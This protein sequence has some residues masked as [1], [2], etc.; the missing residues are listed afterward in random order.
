MRLLYDL[1]YA[2][3]IGRSR[4][5]GGGE[6]AK[7]ILA[8]IL[9]R[10]PERGKVAVCFD[11]SRF[12]D[13]WLLGLLG[14][15][16]VTSYDVKSKEDVSALL[17]S[18]S[19]FDRFYC[20]LP[21]P[22]AS[23]D[24]SSCIE[25]YGTVHGL[26]SLE[27]PTDCYEGYLQ[28]LPGKVKATANR[29]FRKTF[30]NRH[31]SKLKDCVDRLDHVFTVSEHSRYAIA[32]AFGTSKTID[33]A[34]SP[35]KSKPQ[36]IKSVDS[37]KGSAFILL[38]SCNRWEKNARRAVMAL[39]KL[40][41]RGHLDGVKVACCGVSDSRLFAD[42]SHS[43]DFIPLGYVEPGELEWLYKDCAV[44][45]YPT[46]NEGFGYPPLEAMAYGTTC[47]VSGVCSL[48]E[49]CGDAVYYV[50]PYSEFEIGTRVLEALD[51]PK[52]EGLV[53]RQLQA[54][55]ERQRTDLDRLV[56]TLLGEADFE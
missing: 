41:S 5:H 12:L 55:N 20:A 48:P 46:L 6:Y 27:C 37:V 54:V 3:P 32:N 2:Q 15:A 53:A 52:D 25:F 14:D 35:M 50:N 49:I 40:Y 44:F 17:N 51:C 38:V 22:Y 34:Y 33:V 8:E 7:T 29:L 45:L 39:D 24:V 42:L 11:R 23:S 10:G 18:G 43:D 31:Y 16:E 4:F 26:R 13:D 28:D 56:D 19:K 47:V 36:A 30:V 1:L 21:Y 9:S